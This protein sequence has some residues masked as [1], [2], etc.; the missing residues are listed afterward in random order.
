MLAAHPARYGAAAAG[1]VRAI[2]EALRTLER[3]HPERAVPAL[4]RAAAELDHLRDEP[5]VRD[6][7]RAIADAIVAAG[8][9]YARAAAARPVAAPGSSLDITLELVARALPVTVQRIEFRRGAGHRAQGAHRRQARAHP[10]PIRCPVGRADQSRRWTRPSTPGHHNVAD[11]REVG[12]AHRCP[13]RGQPRRRDR[14]RRCASRCRCPRLT[15][16]VRGDAC[17]CSRSSAGDAF[18]R[19]SA[20]P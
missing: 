16:P 10:G 4:V 1:Y 14:R 15:D 18:R 20:T 6:A 11:Q 19:P 3:D 17:G 13:R 12:M 8:G 7:R 2:A 9:L 5:R